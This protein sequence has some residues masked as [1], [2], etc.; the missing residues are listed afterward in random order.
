MKIKGKGSGKI[1]INGAYN[2][3]L[4]TALFSGPVDIGVNE[5]DVLTVGYVYDTVAN[6]TTE[7][8]TVN[9]PGVYRVTLTRKGSPH[10]FDQWSIERLSDSA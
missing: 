7:A 10:W 4:T 6:G 1:Y 5:G 2:K 8:T 3:C 9:E